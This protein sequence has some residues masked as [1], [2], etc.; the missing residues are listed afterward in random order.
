MPPEIRSL[1]RH[2]LHDPVEINIALSKPA[3]GVDQQAYVV[4]DTQKMAVVEHVLRTSEA[5]SMLLFCGTKKDA[6]EVARHLKRR[7]FDC[8]PMHS[9]L[10]QS[11]REQVM[12]DFRNRKLR[13]LVATNVVSRG[14]DIDDID[15]VINYDVPRDPE[16]YVH[17]V[18][19]TA[20]PAKA[21]PHLREPGRCASSAASSNWSATVREMPLPDSWN[22]ARLMTQ[23][24]DR[25]W[26][27]RRRGRWSAQRRTATGPPSSA[28]TDGQRSA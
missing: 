20:R 1:A 13:L 8:Q 9:D 18:G 3:E 5:R 4:Y 14:I 6:K 24:G 26:C 27:A 10:D 12:L 7:G 11:E 16:D 19:R 28:L 23:R 21:P 22:R 2:T 25:R 15:V 17:R